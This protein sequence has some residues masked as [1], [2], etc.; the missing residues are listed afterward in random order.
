[1]KDLNNF[2]KKIFSQNGE[3]GIVEEI[4]NRLSG[5]L[6]KICCEFGAWDGIHLSNIYNLVNYFN[7]RFDNLFG[8]FLYF[9]WNY[10]YLGAV[11]LSRARTPK[12]LNKS[13]FEFTNRFR[14]IN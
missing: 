14:S 12:R 4:L 13:F 11:N 9:Y 7:E 5:S 1:M 3:D 8:I 6:D 2:K 10:I